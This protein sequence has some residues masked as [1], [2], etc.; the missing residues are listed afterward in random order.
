MDNKIKIENLEN[1]LE[2]FP[3][4]EVGTIDFLCAVKERFKENKI[5]RVNGEECLCLRSWGEIDGAQVFLRVE[6]ISY[7]NGKLV[8]KPKKKEYMVREWQDG[9]EEVRP[10]KGKV[11]IEI[12]NC[13]R[14]RFFDDLREAYTYAK[15][16]A[17]YEWD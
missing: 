3:F 5:Y 13:K 9:E 1:L 14:L 7:D 12:K 11:I 10:D 17:E 4:S 15:S 6:Q 8:I 2:E 16:F